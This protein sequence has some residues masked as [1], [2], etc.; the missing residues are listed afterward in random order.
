MITGRI[1]KDL[2]LESTKNGTS[3]CQF[4]IA[5][6]RPV[7]REGKKETDFINCVIW[8]KQAENLVKFQKKGNL[9]GVIGE[10]R[11]DNYEANGEKKYKTY[12][13]CQEIEFL[14]AKKDMTKEEQKEFNN[15]STKTITQDN[16]KIEDNDLPW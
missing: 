2:T 11:I 14:E 7:I 4:T 6:N 15:L 10:L 13:L 1:V 9:I 3:V 12:I 5:T 8:N 16:I